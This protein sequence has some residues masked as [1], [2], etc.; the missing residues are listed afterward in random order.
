MRRTKSITLYLG[1][2]GSF[3]LSRYKLRRM[4]DG[5]GDYLSTGRQSSITDLE[6]HQGRIVG[7]HKLVGLT[8]YTVVKIRIQVVK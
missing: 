4:N 8:K 3:T 1:Y 7:L 6:E 2:D 5:E